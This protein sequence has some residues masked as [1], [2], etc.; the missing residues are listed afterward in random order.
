M[1][2]EMNNELT[3]DEAMQFKLLEE[4]YAHIKP[5]TGI[6]SLFEHAVQMQK[7]D[8]AIIK[9]IQ[10][11]ELAF[12]VKH[13]GALISEASISMDDVKTFLKNLVG[14]VLHYL[15]VARDFVVSVWKGLMAKY[16]KL[17]IANKYF[18]NKYAKT[19]KLDASIDFEGYDFSRLDERKPDDLMM[20]PT[21]LNKEKDMSEEQMKTLKAK[22][23][24]DIIYGK[25]IASNT[26]IENDE[27]FKSEA[28]D[29]YYG[30]KKTRK[31]KIADQL[32]YIKNT[33][34]LK[35]D[36]SRAFNSTDKAIKAMIIYT[37]GL[38]VASFGTSDLMR[39]ALDMLTTNA[40]YDKMAYELYVSALKDRNKQAK[41][42][43]IAALQAGL[44]KEQVIEKPHVAYR[45]A[46]IES[47]L[48]A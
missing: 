29:W 46:S 22:I 9:S 38:N 4:E 28:H 21:E 33:N 41:A 48:M 36:T 8:I 45:E 40:R 10:E 27:Q 18:Y 11:A 34:K 6:N 35:A 44:L 13:D 2:P 32:Q 25:G 14:K 26:T 23:A 24:H 47:Y 7:N 37:K 20:L 31:Y 39:N 30:F 1:N 5:Y 17:D 43:C 15:E 3:L 19:L 42:I 16:E 12:Y